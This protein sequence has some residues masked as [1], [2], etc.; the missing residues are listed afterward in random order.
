MSIRP[1]SFSAALLA[2]SFLAACAAPD[3]RN[4]A[5]VPQT[6]P[7]ASGY[8]AQGAYP[9]PASQPYYAGYGMVESIQ[10]VNVPAAGNGGIGA[11]ALI[12]GAVGGLLGNQVGGGSGRTAATAA[13]AIGGAIAG[14]QIEQRNRAQ[15][16][17]AYQVVVRLDNGGYQTLVQDS[18]ADLQVG[19]RVR[20]EN[21]RAWRY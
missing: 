11:G 5:P 13:G 14:H 15:N 6:Y 12:G 1:L 10:L 2:A 4:T 9:A 18:V 17:Q 21:G 7:T 8:P 19:S 16:T 3:Y 20:V